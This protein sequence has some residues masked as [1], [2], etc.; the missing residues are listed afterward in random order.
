MVNHPWGGC[1][2]SCGIPRE[3]QGQ[4]PEKVE[5]ATILRPQSKANKDNVI[6]LILLGPRAKPMIDCDLK[7]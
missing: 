4:V 2:C 3:L 6:T 7:D 1:S 5:E